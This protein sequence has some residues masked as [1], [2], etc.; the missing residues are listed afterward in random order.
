V[1]YAK[2]ASG[3]IL[4]LKLYFSAMQGIVGRKSKEGQSHLSTEYHG[5]EVMIH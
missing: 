5:R 2:G 3:A 1:K 4:N